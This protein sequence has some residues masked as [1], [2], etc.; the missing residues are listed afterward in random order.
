MSSGACG[1]GAQPRAGDLGK[2]LYIYSNRLNLGKFRTRENIL[3]SFAPHDIAAILG[4]VGDA[5]PTRLS[6]RGSAY[7][8]A[9]IADVT[10]TNM[11]FANDVRAHIFVSWLHPFKEQRLVVVGSQGM[12][13]FADT[14]PEHKLKVYN[15][16]VKWVDGVPTPVKATPR[17]V[18]Y[19]DIE[20]LRNE[21]EDFLRCIRDRS[22]PV[23]SGP[24]ALKVLQVLQSCQ[25][26]LDH[27][28]KWV[29]PATA[30]ERSFSAHHSAIVEEAEG[31]GARTK[32]W[33]FAHVMP[34]VQTGTACVLGQN[35]FV[36]KNV[37]I[38]NGVRI[39]NNVSLFE[40]V[41]L[42]DD[43]FCGPSCVFT[44]VANPR[45][46]VARHD[47]FKPTVVKHGASIGA[48]AV[49]IC[50]NTIGKYAFIGAG[51]VVT[52]DIPPHALVY[53]NPARRHGWMCACGVKLAK[54]DGRWQCPDCGT[55]YNEVDSGLQRASEDNE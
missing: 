20:P 39:Q 6:A 49:I 35:V 19:P 40:G 26:S 48:N 2:L 52:H 38:G 28:G 27:H 14:D 29:V 33:H 50:G 10:L 31:I 1:T 24:R 42:E 34:G 5:L 3:W 15:H 13:E 41:E 7:L 44:N 47:E 23:S 11:E 53:G 36:G 21:C 55:A 18:A 8:N 22:V 45:S 17:P 30:L 12:A 37:R 46:N 4:M 51:S 25:E 9:D 54:T 43:V 16:Q 32:I